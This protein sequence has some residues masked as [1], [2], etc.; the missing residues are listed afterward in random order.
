MFGIS[1]ACDG[2]PGSSSYSLPSSGTR[3]QLQQITDGG[4]AAALLLVLLLS[5]P[6]RD[7]RH[8]NEQPRCCRLCSDVP[9]LSQGET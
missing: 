1:S 7:H 8:C 6:W 2:K 5:P 9:I 4:G 3:H